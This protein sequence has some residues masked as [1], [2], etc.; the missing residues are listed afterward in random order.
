MAVIRPRN[1]MVYFR[2]TEDEFVR[3]N[4]I[5]GTSGA[6]SISDLARQAVKSLLND[7]GSASRDGRDQDELLARI[8]NLTAAVKDLAAR[9]AHEDNADRGLRKQRNQWNESA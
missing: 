4:R 2:V 8:E 1:R 6:R 3:L 5:C 9:L 7:E